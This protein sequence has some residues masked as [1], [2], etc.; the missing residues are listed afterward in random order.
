MRQAAQSS[1]P[2][3]LPDVIAASPPPIPFWPR[4]LVWRQEGTIWRGHY[5]PFTSLFRLESF[6]G[7]SPDGMND[8]RVL[9]AARDP[10]AR[11][12]L[13]WS[14]LPVATVTETTCGTMVRFADARF[15]RAGSD[16]LTR[17][18]IMPTGGTGCDR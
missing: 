8:P 16:M 4:E 12:Y 18:V 3:A 2:Y 10:A 13:A 9:R 1:P 6:E 14:I 15:T 7:P 11:K 17:T 5:N